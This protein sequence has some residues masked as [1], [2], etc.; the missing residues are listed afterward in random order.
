MSW[1]LRLAMP[2]IIESWLKLFDFLLLLMLSSFAKCK[3]PTVL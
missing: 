2:V 1:K 3:N